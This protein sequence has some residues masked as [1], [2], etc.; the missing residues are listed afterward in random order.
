MSVCVCG[1][2]AP[3]CG[4]RGF[5]AGTVLQSGDGDGDGD[6]GEGEDG[7]AADEVGEAPPGAEG[8]EAAAAEEEP[9]EPLMVELYMDRLK[10]KGDTKRSLTEI[11]ILPGAAFE[12]Y[13]RT[14]VARCLRFSPKEPLPRTERPGR[15]C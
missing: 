6:D 10:K 3:L 11:G 13:G 14:D 7:D 15:D 9:E 2:G 4:S 1:V 5:R 8:A 12:Q